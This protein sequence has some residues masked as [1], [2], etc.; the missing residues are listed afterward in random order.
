MSRTTQDATGPDELDQARIEEIRTKVNRWTPQGASDLMM[1]DL[2]TVLALLNAYDA[3]TAAGKRVEFVV[4][5]P[6]CGE[7]ATAGTT[8]FTDYEP[9]QPLRIDLGMAASQE[10][11]TCTGPDCGAQC[12]SG[13]FEVFTDEDTEGGTPDA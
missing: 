5:C 2:A 11:F 8:L 9:G 1:F 4:D 6:V 3:M 12:Y 13:D 10:T 7:P